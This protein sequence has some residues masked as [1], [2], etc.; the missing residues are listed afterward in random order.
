MLM[1][2]PSRT[3]RVFSAS[4]AQM[5]RVLTDAA[6]GR[7]TL[8]EDESV[9]VRRLAAAQCG[10]MVLTEEED[11]ALRRVAMA[12]ECIKSYHT[13]PDFVDAYG[14]FLILA[15]ELY[16]RNGRR[17]LYDA[18]SYA[19]DTL[20]RC[21]DG[22][23]CITPDDL[24]TLRT[25]GR[26]STITR[27]QV[28]AIVERFKENRERQRR[29][30]ELQRRQEALWHPSA[31]SKANSHPRETWPEIVRQ[32]RGELRTSRY[33]A[34]LRRFLHCVSAEAV[35]P[36]WVGHGTRDGYLDAL[37]TTPEVIPWAAA[38]LPLW[39]QP[40]RLV[41][42]GFGA[43]LWPDATVPASQVP[44]KK[45]PD[46]LWARRQEVKS[47]R[48]ATKLVVFVLDDAATTDNWLG[49]GTRAEYL[50]ALG[51]SEELIA[52]ARDGLSLH[53]PMAEA[54]EDEVTEWVD[55]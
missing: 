41:P 7:L 2:E 14:N 42:S 15:H 47:L 51:I 31:W 39:P 16:E 55:I 50:D 54:S 45:W 11:A 28:D 46:L 19:A 23:R 3:L 43:M 21:Q 1:T 36:D 6:R 26:S 29:H 35:T 38:G 48:Q 24:Q 13:K 52:W 49:H 34:N 44:V 40:E 22:I 32:R 25:A 4:R 20:K 10:P 18:R 9:I 8:S 30:E 27:A 17:E 33:T 53:G 37:G 5:K 12:A